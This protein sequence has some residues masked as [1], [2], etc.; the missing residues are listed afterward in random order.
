MKGGHKVPSK[1]RLI[2]CVA[3][4]FALLDIWVKIT[5]IPWIIKRVR[6][7]CYKLESLPHEQGGLDAHQ[8]I[9]KNHIVGNLISAHCCAATIQIKTG[10]YGVL[11]FMK[12]RPSYDIKFSILTYLK[13][14]LKWWG[15]RVMRKTIMCHVAIAIWN[16]IRISYVRGMMPLID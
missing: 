15:C 14:C 1:K 4:T 6:P 7:V 5:N 10:I 13:F 11:L 2:C 8:I 12:Y 16:V 3:N 9:E